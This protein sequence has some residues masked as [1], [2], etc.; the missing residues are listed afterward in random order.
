MIEH[1]QAMLAEVQI[2]KHLPHQCLT[3]AEDRAKAFA[4]EAQ[5]LR[6]VN[7][8]L[9]VS[10]AAL[11]VKVE[12][13]EELKQSRD[14]ELEESHDLLRRERSQS[15]ITSQELHTLH[16][17]MARTEGELEGHVQAT[18]SLRSEVQLLCK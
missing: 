15:L 10:L 18:A 4:G 16:R 1:L 14:R 12:A 11:Q 8:A 13:Q 6:T 7:E 3:E 5:K 2:D 17:S 9:Q